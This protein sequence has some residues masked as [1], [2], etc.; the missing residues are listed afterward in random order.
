MTKYTRVVARP[1]A[2]N[3]E[4]NFVSLTDKIKYGYYSYLT[5]DNYEFFLC[6]I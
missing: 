3:C 2:E 5:I 6:K 4:D 1:T